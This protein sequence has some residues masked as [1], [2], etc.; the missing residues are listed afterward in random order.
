M[1]E[2]VTPPVIE[3][4]PESR[5]RSPLRM[6]TAR[7]SDDTYH[8]IQEIM[9]EERKDE[10]HPHSHDDRRRV[11]RSR[12]PQR[13]MS[14]TRRVR[15][16]AGEAART[17]SHSRTRPAA[18]PAAELRASSASSTTGFVVRTRRLPSP[19]PS[20][21]RDREP[22]GHSSHRPVSREDVRRKR[23]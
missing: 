2:Y 17:A 5:R 18:Q 19:R 21:Y 10:R 1:I 14:E 3:V 8:E 9:E 12:S 4:E 13:R 22:E 7:I 11:E 6:V 23:V 20:R 15:D 16:D